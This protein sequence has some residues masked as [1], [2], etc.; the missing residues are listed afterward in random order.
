MSAAND[1]EIESLKSKVKQLSQENAY[2]KEQ[3]AGKGC[4]LSNDAVDGIIFL[5]AL[6]AVVI[7]L[8]VWLNGHPS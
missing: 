8:V 6:C 3:V 2:L 5:I 4:G 1:N 7:G